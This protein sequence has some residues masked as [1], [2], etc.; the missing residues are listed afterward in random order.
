MPI[1][2]GE[3]G[4]SW[5]PNHAQVRALRAL[6]IDRKRRRA[7]VQ[8]EVVVFDLQT[9]GE[10]GIAVIQVVGKRIRSGIISI[11][12]VGGGVSDLTRFRGQALDVARAFAANELEIYGG[13]IINQRLEALLLRQGFSRAIEAIPEML[14]G[15]MM[16]IVSKVFP[17]T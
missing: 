7:F 8:G 17:V 11:V 2:S 16:E 15:G 12:D 6:G 14:G 10:P 1:R 13:A 3:P 5:K 9:E 4:K